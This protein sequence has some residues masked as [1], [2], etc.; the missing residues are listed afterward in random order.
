M[1]MTSQHGKIRQI[2]PLCP[3]SIIYS[4]MHTANIQML[5]AC[6]KPESSIQGC[7]RPKVHAQEYLIIGSE[8]PLVMYMTCFTSQLMNLRPNFVRPHVP[9]QSDHVIRHM[10][11]CN[12]EAYAN[13]QATYHSSR[14]T[15]HFT[16]S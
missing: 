14:I 15:R 9:R 11:R 6:V 7:Y 1:K 5:H 16:V 8:T 4:K 10:V 3:K 2:T 12:T 13:I